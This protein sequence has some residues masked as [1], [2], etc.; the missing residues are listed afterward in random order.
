MKRRIICLLASLMMTASTGLMMARAQ[1]TQGPVF[2]A[3]DAPVT[4]EQI[5][6]KLE[7]DGWSNVWISRYGR[8]VRVSGLLNGQAGRIAVDSQTGRL[9]S[10]VDDDDED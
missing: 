4:V 2:I 6:A 1:T 5:K 3:G 7:A 8:Y 10:E 9:L